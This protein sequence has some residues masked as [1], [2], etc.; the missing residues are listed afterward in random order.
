MYILIIKQNFILFNFVKKLTGIIFEINLLKSYFKIEKPWENYNISIKSIKGEKEYAMNK[1]SMVKVTGNNFG[2]VLHYNIIITGILIGG[3]VLLTGRKGEEKT[4]QKVGIKL[5]RF[6]EKAVRASG[7]FAVI[8]MEATTKEGVRLSRSIGHKLV[9]SNV[10]IYGDASQFFN[11]DKM[12]EAEG[13]EGLTLNSS[14]K[15]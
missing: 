2:T 15:L 1:S 13:E 4:I 9:Q 7:E 5:G 11:K 3:I 6:T 12:V 14:K 10:R 8:L